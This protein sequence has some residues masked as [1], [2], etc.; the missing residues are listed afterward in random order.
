MNYLLFAWIIG[1]LN[2]SIVILILIVTIR[3]WKY[4][5]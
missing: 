5:Q 3:I 4:R 2:I 1:I